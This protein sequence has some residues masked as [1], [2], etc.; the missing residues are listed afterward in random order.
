MDLSNVMFLPFT[1]KERLSESFAAADLFIVSLQRGLAGYIVPSKLYGILAAGRPFVAAVEESCEVASLTT[2]HNCGLVAEPGDAVALAAQIRAM[3]H[4]R[5]LLARCGANAREL[6][7]S[8]DRRRQ[9]AR[10]MELFAKVAS[11]RAAAKAAALAR[12]ESS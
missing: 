11:R 8:F 4:D 5:A 7:V 1:P 6:G 3:Y 12:S 2:R 10:Y 9:V